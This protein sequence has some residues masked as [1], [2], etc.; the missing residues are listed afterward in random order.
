M[1]L[2]YQE[3]SIIV[4]SL[5]AANIEQCFIKINSIQSS[6]CSLASD[7]SFT[8]NSLVIKS[9]HKHLD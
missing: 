3:D 9:L 6:F 2:H 8:N 5:L 1:Y 7:W 4:T